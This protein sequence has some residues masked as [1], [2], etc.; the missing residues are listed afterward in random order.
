M[1]D[2][3]KFIKKKKKVHVFKKLK[4]NIVLKPAA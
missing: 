2:I 1:K 4:E 3:I